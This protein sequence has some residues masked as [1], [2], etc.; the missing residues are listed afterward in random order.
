[1]I[2]SK[3]LEPFSLALNA[4]TQAALLCIDFRLVPTPGRESR[5]V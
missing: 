3:G 5:L 1:M 4:F 2:L